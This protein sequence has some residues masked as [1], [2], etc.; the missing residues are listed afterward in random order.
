MSIASVNFPLLFYLELLKTRFSR[1]HLTE[2]LAHSTF[3]MVQPQGTA[4]TR[5]D[6]TDFPITYKLAVFYP[7]LFYTMPAMMF[8]SL[9]DEE[10]S[11]FL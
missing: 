9:V 11:Q 7:V 1:K 3:T 10:L 5:V 2:W 6:Q 8:D 4:E